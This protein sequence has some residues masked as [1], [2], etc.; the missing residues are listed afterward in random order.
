MYILRFEFFMERYGYAFSWAYFLKFHAAFSIALH[1]I[2]LYLVVFM[3][4]IRFMALDAVHFRWMMPKLAW[5]ANDL[6]SASIQPPSFQCDIHCNRKCGISNVRA[7]VPCPRDLHRRYANAD[8]VHGAR[9]IHDSVL[10]AVYGERLQMAQDE[11]LAYGDNAEGT[12]L[13]E[14]YWKGGSP[15]Y[16]RRYR[17]FCFCCSRSLC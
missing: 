6:R 4:F 3:A 5:F 12:Q 13:C 1:A 2:S 16:F 15:R 9:K 17:A 11:P 14:T 10:A 8:I 7:H